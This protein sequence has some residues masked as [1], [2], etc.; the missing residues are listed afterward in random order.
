V[1]LTEY[2]TNEIKDE[3]RKRESDFP[4]DR[5]VENMRIRKRVPKAHHCQF[6]D[7]S[8]QN[9]INSGDCYLCNGTGV[10]SA[11]R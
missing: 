3:L 2:S 11:Y 7:G 4:T 9:V 6:C 8:G 1:S 10:P 5:E